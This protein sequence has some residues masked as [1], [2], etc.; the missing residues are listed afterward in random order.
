M[1]VTWISLGT[2]EMERSGHI[3]VKVGPKGPSH[4]LDVWVTEKGGTKAN[5]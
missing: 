2:A 4:G 5:Y 1:L 3:Q